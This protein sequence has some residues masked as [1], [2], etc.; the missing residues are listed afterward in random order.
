VLPLF[1]TV[2]LAPW[3]AAQTPHI[4]DPAKATKLTVVVNDENGVP[5]AGARV[6]LQSAQL[7]KARRCET[8]FAGHCEFTALASGAYEVHVEKSNF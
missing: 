2:V 1:L 6:Q 5:V 3:L 8:D 7:P 4:A